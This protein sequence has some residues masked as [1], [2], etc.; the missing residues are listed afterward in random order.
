MEAGGVGLAGAD[1]D[2]EATTGGVRPAVGVE[3]NDVDEATADGC[4]DSED[5]TAGI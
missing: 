1:G 5:T 4:H 3:A 2:D